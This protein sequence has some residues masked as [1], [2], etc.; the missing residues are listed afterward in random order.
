MSVALSVIW[1]GLA[2]RISTRLVAVDL[3]NSGG[4]MLSNSFA[5]DCECRYLR[6]CRC[7]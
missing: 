3:N 6:N 7:L 4:L 5:A 1:L 2:Y